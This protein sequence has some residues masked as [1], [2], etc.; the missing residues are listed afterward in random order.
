[1]A[2]IPFCTYIGSALNCI[3]P[4]SPICLS[5]KPGPCPSYIG[6]MPHIFG[7]AKVGLPSPPLRTTI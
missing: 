3:T 5:A 2:P 7:S 6:A 1:M 4:V